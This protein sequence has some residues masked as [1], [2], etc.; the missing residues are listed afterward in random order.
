VLRRLSLGMLMGVLLSG[1]SLTST[2]GVLAQG[3]ADLSLT[4]TGPTRVKSG[5]VV[6]YTIKLTNLGPE[7]AT[8][9]SIIG[10][11]GDQFN[12][13]SMHCQDNGS[14]GQSACYPPD[15]AP[16]GVATASYSVRVCCLVRGENRDAFIGASAGQDVIPD[17]DPNIENNWVQKDVHIIGG[18]VK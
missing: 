1:L 17:P 18:R 10:G 5:E 4:M 7:T 15:L 6:V 3:G 12:P 14:F 9:I 16:G 8:R 13:V 11:G 2:A